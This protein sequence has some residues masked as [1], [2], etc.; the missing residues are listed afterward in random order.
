MRKTSTAPFAGKSISWVLKCVVLLLLTG[1]SS[2]QRA[3]E[4]TMHRGD[5][6]G[7]G[8]SGSKT[9]ATEGKLAWEFLA[10]SRIT[11]SPVVKDGVLYIGDWKSVFYAIDAKT[12]KQIW[13]TAPRVSSKPAAPKSTPDESIAPLLEGTSTESQQYYSFSNPCLDDH[14]VFAATQQ[15]IVTAFERSTGKV[16]WER[17]FDAEI[18]S[19]IRIVDGR[20]IFGCNDNFLHCLNAETGETVWAY[21]AADWI[22][23]TCVITRGGT[24]ITPSHDKFLHKIDLETGELIEKFDVGYRSTGTPC[25][26]LG[27]VYF[28]ATGRRFMCV[29]VR[30]GATRWRHNATSTHQQGV[31]FRDAKD[32]RI[33]VA[34][35]RNVHCY[36]AITGAEIW[37]F[38]MDSQSAM[39]PCLGPELLYIPDRDGLLYA[40]DIETGKERWRVTYGRGSWTNPV[41]VDGLVYMAGSAGRVSAFR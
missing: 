10:Q 39:S 33:W 40:L 17:E 26:Y 15:G 18:F 19:S 28:C 41:L 38:A 24:I 4:W 12:G 6:L 22:G 8:R 7:S 36:D 37:R 32:R 23:A 34:I 21:A 29:D 5:L 27:N 31:A 30:N 1:S 35:H 2:A 25:L 20:I 11:V 14:R 16:V 13:S 3:D 9:D